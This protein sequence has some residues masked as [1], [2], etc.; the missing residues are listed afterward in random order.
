MQSDPAKN[1]LTG[2][3][4]YVF[5]TKNGLIDIKWSAS[6]GPAQYDLDCGSEE[7]LYRKETEVNKGRRT[8]KTSLFYY[9]EFR[10]RK[11]N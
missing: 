8:S 6:F 7:R 1:V 9:N 11:E 3:G 2:I 5:S 4:N 10:D